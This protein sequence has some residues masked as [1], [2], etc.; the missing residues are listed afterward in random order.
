MHGSLDSRP[1]L[2][3]LVD[4]LARLHGRLKSVFAVSWREAGLGESEAMVLNAVV[5]AERLPTVPQ[6]GRSLGQA[7]QLVQRAANT[8]IERGMIET[9]ANPDHK[10]AV[11]LRATDAGFALK[12]KID[13]EADAIG[14]SLGKR[15]DL[16]NARASAALL[17]ILR[18]Q[19]EAQVRGREMNGS[20]RV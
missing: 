11:L 8:L 15:V 20:D 12:R 14:S 3:S 16:D 1:P 17:R 6:I 18:K 9:L 13:A 10:R 19:L 4:E 2:T 7:R 5:E